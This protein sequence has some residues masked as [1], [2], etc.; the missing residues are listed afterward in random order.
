MIYAIIFIVALIPIVLLINFIKR[1]IHDG[2]NNA[3]ES[4]SANKRSKELQQQGS[5]TLAD[6]YAGMNNNTQPQQQYQQSNNDPQNPY[7]R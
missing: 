7:Q 2:V 5:Q 6:R 3:F 4:I 1:K